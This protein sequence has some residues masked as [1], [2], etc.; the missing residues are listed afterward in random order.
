ML[1]NDKIQL[2]LGERKIR[3]TALWIIPATFWN[4]PRFS[5]I[6]FARKKAREISKRCTRNCS[7]GSFYN[8]YIMTYS[9][10]IYPVSFKWLFVCRKRV[11]LQANNQVYSKIPWDKESLA[12]LW[13]Q[14][15]S[16]ILDRFYL[17]PL[18]N[19][20]SSHFSSVIKRDPRINREP[21]RRCLFIVARSGVAAA[22]SCLTQRVEHLDVF[23]VLYIGIRRVQLIKMFDRL[24][25]LKGFPS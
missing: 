4:F 5:L 23:Q 16:N 1:K 14:R 11:D 18:L 9:L 7:Q 3:I 8:Y 2:P 6:C 10:Q 20:N 19:Q 25:G 12:F 21:Q 13:A 24:K 17:F 15:R 22:L